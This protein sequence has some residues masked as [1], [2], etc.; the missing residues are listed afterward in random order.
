MSKIRQNSLLS[1]ELVSSDCSKLGN[2]CYRETQSSE[3][4]IGSMVG[5]EDSAFLYKLVRKCVRAIF[6]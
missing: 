4:G 2:K 5:A 6:E 1:K 3:E